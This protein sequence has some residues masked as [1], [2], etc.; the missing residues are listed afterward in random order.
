MGCLQFF[1]VRQFCI[2]RP[3]FVSPKCRRKCRVMG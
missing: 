2:V 1:V 3:N